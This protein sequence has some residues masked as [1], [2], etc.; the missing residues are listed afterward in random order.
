MFSFP[1]ITVRNIVPKDCE[2]MKACEEGN[3][4][5]VWDMMVAGKGAA[6]DIDEWGVPALHVRSKPPQG[7]HSLS[8]WY[9]R[10]IRSQSL[11]TVKLLLNCGANANAVEERCFRYV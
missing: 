11:E 6:T 10:A 1:C 7:R 5:F 8:C 9:K 4:D 2:F 3:A